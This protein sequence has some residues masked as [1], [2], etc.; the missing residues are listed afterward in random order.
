MRKYPYHYELKYASTEIVPITG[1][2]PAAF[3]GAYSCEEYVSEK[4]YKD[5][6]YIDKIMQAD[7]WRE[8]MFGYHWKLYQKMECVFRSPDGKNDKYENH[9]CFVSAMVWKDPED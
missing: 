5:L 7:G 9:T 8:K 2:N 3:M 1:I 6:E 4:W